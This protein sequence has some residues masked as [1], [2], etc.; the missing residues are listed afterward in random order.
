MLPHPILPRYN[1]NPKFESLWPNFEMMMWQH[2]AGISRFRQNSFINQQ[3]TS[4]FLLL[5]IFIFLSS[6]VH[7][8]WVWALFE[9]NSGLMRPPRCVKTS[10][11]WDSGFKNEYFTSYYNFASKIRLKLEIWYV[12]RHTV[13]TEVSPPPQKHHP[14]FLDK[15]L[16]LKSAN[17]PSPPFLGNPPSILVFRDPPP[18]PSLS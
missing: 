11:L 9:A 2:G 3:L 7:E 16:P 14:F 4:K 6:L 5:F 12:I 10:K 8:I 15:P 18:L 1:I 13:C 17:C